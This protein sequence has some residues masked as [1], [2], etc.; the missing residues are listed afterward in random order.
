[1]H[2]LLLN[3][4]PSLILFHF[5]FPY[6][7][8]TLLSLFYFL[9][10]KF[11]LSSKISFLLHFL[12]FFLS[13]LCLCSLLLHSVSL[14]YFHLSISHSVFS[15]SSLC[16]YSLPS[17]SSFCIY[18]LNPPFLLLFSFLYILLVDLLL[19]YSIISLCFFNHFLALL[20]HSTFSLHFLPL[21]YLFISYSY[22]YE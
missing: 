7:R 14:L 11:L 18:F 21:C 4:F 3:C 10:G 5:I 19:F 20:S 13:P 16:F 8:S 17:P 12:F 2:M 9:H 22:N 15:T 1:M 6:S